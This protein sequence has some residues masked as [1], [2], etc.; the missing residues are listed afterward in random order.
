MVCNHITAVILCNHILTPLLFPIAFL[1]Q[2]S[3]VYWLDFRGCS[4]FTSLDSRREC[5]WDS[6]CLPSLAG[7]PDVSRCSSCLL[8][9]WLRR[10]EL[11]PIDRWDLFRPPFL[12]TFSMI[13]FSRFCGFTAE[14]EKMLAVNKIPQLRQQWPK[15]AVNSPPPPTS[16][17]VGQSWGFI[18]QGCDETTLGICGPHL[19]VSV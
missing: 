10:V 15:S 11:F 19:C 2:K 3:Q 17:K 8:V 1:H 4:V 9:L 16:V 5:T 6:K 14:G 7:V 13:I 12:N 18:A